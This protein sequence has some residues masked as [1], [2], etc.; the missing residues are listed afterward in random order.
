MEKAGSF[1]LIKVPRRIK[2][3]PRLHYASVA[4]TLNGAA[5]AEDQSGITASQLDWSATT[6]NTV[7][8]SDN[9]RSTTQNP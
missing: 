2:M 3:S 4:G 5:T 7:R 9:F 6:P 1:I 8:L